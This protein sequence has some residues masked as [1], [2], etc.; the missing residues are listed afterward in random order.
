MGTCEYRYICPLEDCD[1]EKNVSCVGRL[2]EYIS[3]AKAREK[4]A[5][6]KVIE[7]VE[8]GMKE[9]EPMIRYLCDHRACGS[10]GGNGEEFC[11]YTPDIRHAKNFELFGKDFFEMPYPQSEKT[12]L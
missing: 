10:C 6:E 2:V 12:R 11:N 9:T 1:Q 8:A 7:T 5:K 3:N 4:K